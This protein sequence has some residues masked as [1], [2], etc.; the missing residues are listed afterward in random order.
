MEAV[1]A[2]GGILLLRSPPYARRR[3]VRD[4][5]GWQRR[6]EAAVEAP[7][8]RAADQAPVVLRE[9]RARDRGAGGQ[10][11]QDGADGVVAD[12]AGG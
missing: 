2:A 10:P 3:E 11:R 7:E 5:R 9:R 8:L 1:V 6:A 12:A 4:V